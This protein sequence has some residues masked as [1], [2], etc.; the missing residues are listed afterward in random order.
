MSSSSSTS[1]IV[2][3]SASGH[4]LLKIEGHS[5]T[6]RDLRNGEGVVSRCFTVA[7]HQWTIRYYPNGVNKL[8]HRYISLY[9]FLADRVASSVTAR[10][11]FSLASAAEERHH[12]GSKKTKLKSGEVKLVAKGQWACGEFVKRSDLEKSEHLLMDDSFT[13]RCDIVVISG[14]RAEDSAPAMPREAVTVPPSDLGRHL[15]GLLETGSGADATFE[16]AGEKF[17]AH[18]WL[19]A[20]RSPA[21]SAELLERSGTADGV[22]SVDKMEPQVFKALLYFMY[23]DELSLPETTTKQEEL[24]FAQH[25]LVAAHRYK[26]ERLKLICEKRLCKSIDVGTAANI[27]A[28]VEPLGCREL[29]DACLDILR[30]LGNLST[31]RI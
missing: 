28:L 1:S 2:V 8:F 10:V 15:R 24:A 23:T 4:H 31:L 22:V 9:L 18:R 30:S 14:F 16:V 20:A 3:D 27:L 26:M 5:S 17:A 11:Q 25:M 7:G 19:L 6:L 12:L 13:V 21:F 29:K